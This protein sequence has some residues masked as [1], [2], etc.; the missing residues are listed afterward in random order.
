[1]RNSISH[2]IKKTQTPSSSKR[3]GHSVLCHSELG[4]S[5]G[6]ALLEKVTGLAEAVT[7]GREHCT[8]A[9]AQRKQHEALSTPHRTV[10]RLDA[11]PCC[12]LE[13]KGRQHCTLA[14]TLPWPPGQAKQ[15]L[16][17]LALKQTLSISNC[18]R[19]GRRIIVKR[20]GR[21]L[22]MWTKNATWKCG[23]TRKDWSWE[24]LRRS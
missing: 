18:S 1:M 23:S 16:L 11:K 9:S 14:S 19:I 24:G 6:Q 8:R 3:P 7:R 5:V 10:S 17:L 13:S 4:S 22:E 12:D 2:Y 15:R 20:P 21:V